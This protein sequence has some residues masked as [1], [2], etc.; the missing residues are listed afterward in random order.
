ME[1][2]GQTRAKRVA[3]RAAS[4]AAAREVRE[5]AVGME[6]EMR[7]EAA[8]AVGDDRWMMTRE[9]LRWRAHNEAKEVRKPGIIVGGRRAALVHIGGGGNDAQ[10]AARSEAVRKRRRGEA[11][12]IR[13]YGLDRVVGL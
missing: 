5:V 12:E 11:D 3:M 8:R 10:G 13:R 7:V 4:T 9:M 1:K 2:Q 6:Q